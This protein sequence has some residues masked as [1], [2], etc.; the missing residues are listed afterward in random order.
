MSEVV[1]T[2]SCML[3]VGGNA[4]KSTNPAGSTRAGGCTKAWWDSQPNIDTVAGKQTAMGKLMGSD[5]EPIAT[6]STTAHSVAT[7]NRVKITDTSGNCG[8]DNAEVGMLIYHH[9]DAA[10]IDGPGVYTICEVDPMGTYIVLD[11]TWAYT[12]YMAGIDGKT[13]Q[14]GGAWDDVMS[15]CEFYI[16]AEMYTQEVWVNKDLVS[17]GQWDWSDWSG[18]V[19][20]NTWL[21][22]TGFHRVPGDITELDGA[23]FQTTKSMKVDGVHAD[24]LVHIDMSLLT[25]DLISSDNAYNITMRGFHFDSPVATN[26]MFELSIGPWGNIDL[27][28]NEFDL[29]CRIDAAKCRNLLIRDSL[30]IPSSVCTDVLIN[31]D[32]TSVVTF[33]NNYIK[34]DNLTT[35][36]N[37]PFGAVYFGTGN[38][39]DLEGAYTGVLSTAEALVISFN[40]TYVG[41]ASEDGNGLLR[42]NS[43]ST[44][45]SIND[46]IQNKMADAR[47]FEVAKF[48]G[49]HITE[50]LCAYS[51]EGQITELIYLHVDE[52]TGNIRKHDIVN[53]LEVDPLLDG[54]LEPLEDQVRTG[55]SPDILGDPTAIGAIKTMNTTVINTAVQAA[56]T[57][58]GYTTGRAPKLDNIDQSISSVDALVDAVILKTDNLPADPAGVSDL[59]SVDT[60]AV[61]LAA[62]GLDNIVV[63]EPSGDPS[64]WSFAQCV[65]WLIMRFFNKHTSDNFSGIVVHKSDGTTSTSQAVTEVDGVKA[66]GKAQ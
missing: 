50:N 20:N 14:V 48:G 37:V 4:A 55:G 49:S 64:G 38:V 32:G 17:I 52:S 62:D 43:E 12:G 44:L 61:K 29:G 58:Q 66:V 11:E 46:I 22:V 9:D 3:F 36:I 59:A 7:D 54:D 39:V 35:G 63:A 13:V 42:V 18:D 51:E 8:F 5:G 31:M 25:G 23:Y 6:I 53:L 34:Q 41:F 19:Y 21:K 56:L 47:A 26:G 45:V 30:I 16:D 27:A 28:H 57:S 33:L 40:N 15:L 65:R 10:L 2:K 1:D 24:K 60:S